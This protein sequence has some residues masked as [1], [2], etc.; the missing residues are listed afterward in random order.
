MLAKIEY[1]IR[2][3][4]WA[5]SEARSRGPKPEI[6]LPQYIIDLNEKSKQ[7]LDKDDIEN[8]YNWIYD[9]AF[10]APEENFS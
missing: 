1:L 5:S 7:V 9:P 6:D 10:E 4:I 3:Y 8:V 2:T